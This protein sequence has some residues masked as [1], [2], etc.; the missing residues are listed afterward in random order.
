MTIA[1]SA[2]EVAAKFYEKLGSNILSAYDNTVLVKS[3]SLKELLSFLK[4][5]SGLEFNYLNNI[6]AI[7][8]WDYFELVYQ[9]TSLK[10]NHK[11]T[12]KTQLDGRENLVAPSIVDIFKGAD[13][14][15]REIHDLM[16]IIFE[17]HPNLKPILLWEGFKG[18][19]LRKDYL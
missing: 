15:E 3:E 19:P 5:T 13:Y 1:L 10:F 17:G 12:V 7:D 2:K 18:F 11:L 9:L 16:G 6:T 4:D 8:Y 14:Q